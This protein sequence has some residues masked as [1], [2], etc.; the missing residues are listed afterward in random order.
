V[1]I[2]LLMDG[3]IRVPLR[4]EMDGGVGDGL[5]VLKPDHPDYVRYQ[6]MVEDEEVSPKALKLDI[7]PDQWLRDENGRFT[8]EGHGM[9]RGDVVKVPVDGAL[10]EA[11]VWTVGKDTVLVRV[12]GS[13]QHQLVVPLDE[14]KKPSDRKPGEFRVGDRVGF[15]QR[16]TTSLVLDGKRTEH[17]LPPGKYE[18][19]VLSIVEKNGNLRVAVD[20]YDGAYTVVAA[21]RAT[22]V[23][24]SKPEPKPE[25]PKPKPKPEPDL[26]VGQGVV[27]IIGGSEY[28]QAIVQAVNGDQITVAFDDGDTYTIPRSQVRPLPH[29][30]PST[31]LD[32]NAPLRDRIQAIRSQAAP[33]VDQMVAIGA[34]VEKDVLGSKT[35]KEA[36]AAY[37]KSTADL[38][39]AGVRYN[40]M[41]EA[42]KAL[43]RESFVPDESSI[44]HQD[45]TQGWW[46]LLDEVDPDHSIREGQV[47]AS[48]ENGRAFSA[49]K[50]AHA[51]ALKET[52]K[53]VRKMGGPPPRV[54]ARIPLKR[55][56][57]GRSVE[58]QSGNLPADWNA[59]V[60]GSGGINLSDEVT[61]AFCNAPRNEIH[62]DGAN[63]STILHEMGHMVDDKVP[64]L[65]LITKIFWRKRVA[66]EQA[67]GKRVKVGP[68]SDE[69]GYSD[70]FTNDY[71]GKDYGNAPYTEITSMGLEGAFHNQHHFWDDTYTDYGSADRREV[72]GDLEWRRL[73]LGALAAL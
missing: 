39:A 10:Q 48:K 26:E 13:R 35:V 5:V 11:T 66:E 54:Y 4:A 38:K 52:L 59:H 21:D 32:P 31:S 36:D 12:G 28:D 62:M 3:S 73:I 49:K 70:G 53:T 65:G 18:G 60:D 43:A 56:T 46:K 20:G 25:P 6:S 1:K 47:A 58:V 34:E 30:E 61:R 41:A 17:K 23:D 51:K 55:K 64:R 44:F 71:I 19:E 45:P 8:N 15:T 69:W 9:S 37:E 57:L 7:P 22:L 63:P 14:V 2:T 72:P 33:A 29:P 16:H 24:G 68:D 27:A 50:G 67:K 40:E 42:A